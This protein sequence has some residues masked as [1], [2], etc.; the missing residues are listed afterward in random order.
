MTPSS[1]Y[2]PEPS[3]SLSSGIPKSRMARTPSL[4]SSSASRARSSIEK[5]PIAG[6]SGFGCEDGPT[7]SG[8]TKS[9]RSRRVSRTRE[10]NRSVR[11]RRRSRVIGKVLMPES[12]RPGRLPELESVPFRIRGPGE[13]A[14][15]RVL[16]PLVHLN[17]RCAELGE[18]R[19]QVAHAVVQ[20]GLLVAAAEVLGVLGEGR[21]DRLIAAR[22]R[23]HVLGDAEVL[24]VPR[25]QRVGVAGAKEDAAETE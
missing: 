22:G 20:H 13:A 21:P 12:L 6:S 9:S 16:D 24:S 1:S 14:V 18:H 8:M 3:S 15:L 5:R 25:V 2:A 7:K 4:T 17:A 11:R 19:V 23:E 10:R